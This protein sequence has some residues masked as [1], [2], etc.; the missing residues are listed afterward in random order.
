MC[1]GCHKTY[2][3]ATKTE[4]LRLRGQHV[5]KNSTLPKKPSKEAIVEELLKHWVEE[6]EYPKANADL[7]F[8]EVKRGL[9]ERNKRVQK[10]KK[11][12]PKRFK[13]KHPRT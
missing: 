11:T 3:G 8:K 4:W 7:I 2:S 13:K 1:F 5:I 12:K 10:T 6:H 9:Y